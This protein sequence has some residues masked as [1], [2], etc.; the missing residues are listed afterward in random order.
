MLLNAHRATT[1][2]LVIDFIIAEQVRSQLQPCIKVKLALYLD[3]IS[4]IQ[5]RGRR[6]VVSGCHSD[7]NIQQLPY[8]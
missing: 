7:G 4:L 5:G 8:I 3:F 2:L 6:M 1:K